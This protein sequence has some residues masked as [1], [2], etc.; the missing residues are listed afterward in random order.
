M[1]NATQT[2]LPNTQIPN[3]EQLGA[4]GGL[5]DQDQ[6]IKQAQ[7]TNDFWT[8]FLTKNEA[9]IE[10]A[11]PQL[12]EVTV[13]QEVIEQT[14]SIS[15]SF[16][17]FKESF[18]VAVAEKTESVKIES[19]PKTPEQTVETIT[20]QEVTPIEEKKNYEFS[21]ASKEGVLDFV[22]ANF[23]PQELFEETTKFAKKSWKQASEVFTIWKMPLWG[24]IKEAF[25]I[26]KFQLGIEEPKK[27]KTPEQKQKEEMEKKKKAEITRSFYDKLRSLAY[28]KF[29]QVQ[30]QRAKDANKTYGV[31]ESYQGTLNPDGSVRIDVQN[32]IELEN[33]R[34]TEEQIRQQRKQQV[35]SAGKGKKKGPGGPSVDFNM[36][37]AGGSD[38]HI[39]KIAG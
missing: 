1:A 39:L 17:Q 23:Q 36:E 26:M 11:K 34:K 29:G 7:E 8:N 30:E 6:A 16:E 25:S 33:S 5:L 12:T 14:P 15:S 37:K 20:V 9:S 27:E 31:N 18:F 10:P 4:Q 22:K 19:A 28:P 13:T 21:T 38:N 2:K 24:E 32:F 3:Y 35:M